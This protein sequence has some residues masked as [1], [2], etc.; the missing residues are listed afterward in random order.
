[1]HILSQ[2]FSLFLPEKLEVWGWSCLHG[3]ADRLRQTRLFSSFVIP[4]GRGMMPGFAGRFDDEQM[5]ALLPYLHTGL[6]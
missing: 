3:R 4:Q 1:L 6:G 5:A 2:C